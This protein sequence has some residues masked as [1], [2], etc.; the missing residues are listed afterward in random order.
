MKKSVTTA[1][2]F[3]LVSAATAFDLDAHNETNGFWGTD[4]LTLDEAMHDRKIS[5]LIDSSS[6]MQHDQ[7]IGTH[8]RYDAY[9]KAFILR[10]TLNRQ[11]A[12]LASSGPTVHLARE[13][14]KFN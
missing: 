11:T 14:G 2:L 9:Q 5:A 1:L 4:A 6:S 7:T 3:S 8:R 12:P 13:A 10:G